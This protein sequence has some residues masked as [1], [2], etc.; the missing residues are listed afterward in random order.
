MA[1]SSKQQQ[2]QQR[3]EEAIQKIS[4]A[5]GFVR[6]AGKPLVEFLTFIVPLCLVH[7]RRL[8]DAYYKLPQNL[9]Q[10]NL[11]VVFCFFGG[12]Y[13]VLFAAIQAAEHGGRQEWR[14]ATKDIGDEVLKIIEESKKE[15][16]EDDVK[17]L[18]P[19]EFMRRKT[20]LVL[21]KM[22]PEKIDRAVA[23][24][25]SVWLSVAAVLKIEFARTISMALAIADFLKKPANRHLSPLIQMAVPAEYSRWV[26]V[27]M[28]WVIKSFAM[29]IA[30]YIEA[31]RSAFASALTGGL[32]M[33]RS[34][35]VWLQRFKFVKIKHQSETSVDEVLSYF[36]AACGFYFQFKLGFSVP[37]PFNLLLFPFEIAEYYIK[38]SITSN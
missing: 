28:G 16:D 34:T 14:K 13:P 6:A 8:R 22:D 24:M 20:Q 19:K 2:I 37:Y 36:F 3:K 21:T 1:D 35:L 4:K 7:S 29:S 17:K 25:Y 5:A 18:P 9:L 10:F 31:I 12:L 33:A 27:I 11:G 32:L 26:P 30:W 15:D 38:W 23:S